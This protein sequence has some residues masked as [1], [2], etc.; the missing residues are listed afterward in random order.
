MPNSHICI[1]WFVAQ[2]SYFLVH[3]GKFC[4][5]RKVPCSLNICRQPRRLQPNPTQLLSVRYLVPQYL[6]V[7]TRGVHPA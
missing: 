7:E 6:A 2:V 1:A 3:Q 4:V 5:D